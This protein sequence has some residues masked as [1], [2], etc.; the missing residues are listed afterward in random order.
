MIPETNFVQSNMENFISQDNFIREFP[1]KKKKKSPNG[2][3]KYRTIEWRN[4]KKKHPEVTTQKFSTIAAKNWNEMTDNEKNYY[5]KLKLDKP[6]KNDK[7]R[8]KRKYNKKKDNKNNED[9]QQDISEESFYNFQL[10]FNNYDENFTNQDDEY[11]L[12]PFYPIYYD[13]N[14]FFYD[15]NFY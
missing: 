3:I 5:T 15:F 4:F 12:L 7:D 1:D 8:L 14:L 11:L 13:A 9:N 2:F 10:D 6:R